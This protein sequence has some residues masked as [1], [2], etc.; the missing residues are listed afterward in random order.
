MVWTADD[1][2]L[3][4][5][6]DKTGILQVPVQ[7][8]DLREILPLDES[9]DVDFHEISLL[10]NGHDVAFVVHREDPASEERLVDSLVVYSNGERKEVLRLE[11]ESIQSVASSPSGYLLFH[12]S[13]TTPG[14]WALPFS[15]LK[16][17]ATGEPFLVAA[18]S[19]L[20]SVS[21][22]GKLLLVH[23]LTLLSYEIVEVDRQGNV[24]RHIVEIEGDGEA[25]HLS[26]DGT[27]IAFTAA[28]AGNWDTW[29]YDLERKSNTR[30]T[31]D[32]TLDGFARWSPSGDEILYTATDM[33]QVRLKAVDG[34][35]EARTVGSGLAPDWI[36]DGTGF[37]FEHYSDESD[38]W[39]I[40]YKLF[41]EDEAI[42]LLDT[43]ANEISAMISPDGR[44]FVYVSDEAGT[45][46]VFVRPFPA[47]EGKWQ[48]S[49][50]GGTQPR[51]SPDGREIFYIEG[52]ALMAA[53]VADPD[54]FSLGSPVKL[55]DGE[56]SLPLFDSVRFAPYGVGGEG[57]SFFLSRAAEG[58]ATPNRLMLIQN[59]TAELRG[60]D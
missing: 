52:E 19:W 31:F 41:D 26:P 27:R 5:G 10:P 56:F 46:E 23:G 29:I 48:V 17:E 49:V 25:P 39:D 38:T 54:T 33:R 1:Q 18:D 12:R 28:E 50:A 57:R 58:G 15:E 55:M 13:T 21:E 22:D 43:S 34:S 30:F 9:R 35:G 16:S 60:Q 59:W 20:P 40:S 24:I 42:P 53:E 14:V 3:V 37:V 8:G 2:L 7:G 32:S 44:Y 45:W 36:P 4:T 47:G 6:G 51:W 11:G